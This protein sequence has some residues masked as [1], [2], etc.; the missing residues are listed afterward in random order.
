M[1]G[2]WEIQRADVLVAILTREIVATKWAASLRDLQ[3]PPNSNIVWFSGMPFDHARN[4]AC[5]RAL[6]HNYKW[7]FFLD[8]DV[9]APSDTIPR[10]IAHNKPIISGLYYRRA[11]PISPVMLRETPQGTTWI[12][13][14]TAGE[15]CS[16]DLVGAGCLL[17]STQVLRQVPWPWFDWLLDHPELPERERCSEDFAFCRK[18]RKV[19]HQIMVDTSIQCLHIGLGQSGLGGTFTPVKM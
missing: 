12:N 7:L 16:V 13:D 4:T 8:D 15:L 3:L 19:G 10:L 5:Q 1:P 11:A 14:F 18:A 2:A 17:I 6:E 9:L